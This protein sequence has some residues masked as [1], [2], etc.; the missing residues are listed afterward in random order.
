M[1]ALLVLYNLVR[2]Y[3]LTKASNVAKANVSHNKVNGTHEDSLTYLFCLKSKR[4]NGT[5][6]QFPNFYFK[7]MTFHKDLIF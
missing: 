6:G 5:E 3:M 2:D 1:S 4:H 7:Q